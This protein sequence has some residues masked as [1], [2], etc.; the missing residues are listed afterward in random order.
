VERVEGEGRVKA[1]WDR[2]SW[3]VEAFLDLYGGE[4]WWD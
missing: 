1:W 4:S 3:I 2:S